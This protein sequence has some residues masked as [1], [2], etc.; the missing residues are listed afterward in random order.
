MKMAC[1]SISKV[2]GSVLLDW[3]EVLKP[4]IAGVSEMDTFPS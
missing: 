1:T 3:G 4:A 2:P